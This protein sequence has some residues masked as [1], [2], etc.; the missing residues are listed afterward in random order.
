MAYGLSAT[1]GGPSFD[2]TSKRGRKQR[3]CGTVLE[4]MGLRHLWESISI[5]RLVLHCRQ[6]EKRLGSSLASEPIHLA[7]CLRCRRRKPPE[8]KETRGSA[9]RRHENE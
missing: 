1:A 5:A 2:K 7:G 9:Q 3:K 8:N 6:L 4:S